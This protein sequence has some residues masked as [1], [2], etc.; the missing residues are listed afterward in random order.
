MIHKIKSHHPERKD[1]QIE[2]FDG[3]IIAATPAWRWAIGMTY[4]HLDCKL[5]D[6]AWPFT[7][8]PI[9]DQTKRSASLGTARV[10]KQEPKPSDADLA[11]RTASHYEGEPE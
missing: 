4:A 3:K 10:E 2:T 8:E 7:L 11:R 1:G 9:R 5:A 6:T